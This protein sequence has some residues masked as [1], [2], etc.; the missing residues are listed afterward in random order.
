MPNQT[1]ALLEIEAAWSRSDVIVVT[2]PTAAGKTL[3][4]YTLARWAGSA[5]LL[6]PTNLLVDQ[7]RAVFP[8]VR[9]LH[10]RDTYNCLDKAHEQPCEC[11]AT[12]AASMA[13][14]SKIARMNYWVYL[15]NKVYKPVAVFDEGHQVIDMLQGLQDIKL[16]QSE[17]GFPPGLRTVGDL[18]E[19]MQTVPPTER[20]D[21]ILHKVTRL[22]RHNTVVYTHESRRGCRDVVLSVKP[23]SLRD[24][25]G[26]LWPPSVRKVVLMSATVGP[27]D[28]HELGLSDRRVTYVECASP[29]TATNRPLVYQPAYSLSRDCLPHA[30]PKVVSILQAH[31]ATHQEKGLI[32]MP[33]SL[34]A[35]LRPHLQHERLIW[36]TKRDKAR[37][38]ER[39]LA[40]PDGVLV[41]SGLYEGL[42]LPYDAARWQVVAKVPFPSLADPWIRERAD[43]DSEWYAWQA[44]KK[45]IQA[46]GR[47]V[48]RPDDYGVTY[49]HD[50]AFGRLLRERRGLFPQ[51]VLDALKTEVYRAP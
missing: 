32:H 9:V 40:S 48:R 42:D 7:N 11:R 31:L 15:A 45:L 35:D 38:V 47:V 3:L 6:D 24:S 10:R 26:L 27:K 33:Y 12:A 39:F 5:V 51:F 22:A 16:W 41:A 23:H 30:V 46:Y 29:I 50:T 44:A 2:A 4:G 34:A 13:R 36:H 14:T 18:I 25:G 21:E 28:V 19:W 8:E 20:L 17:T 1:T 43:R 49:V 37:A